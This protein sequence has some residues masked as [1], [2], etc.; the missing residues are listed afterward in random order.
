MS[1]APWIA[2]ACT[3][4]GQHPW[5]QLGDLN[6]TDGLVRANTATVGAQ[7]ATQRRPEC[8]W[9]DH[10]DTTRPECRVHV[11]CPRCRRHVQWRDERAREIISTLDAAGRNVLDI[12][13]L[14]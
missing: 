13:R 4:R 6:T 14:P 2:V 8:V 9:L 11:R 12:S 10:L 7:H 1:R 3:D 5:T